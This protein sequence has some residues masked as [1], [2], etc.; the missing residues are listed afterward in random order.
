MQVS[1]M[2]S[3]GRHPHYLDPA[4]LPDAWRTRAERTGYQQTGRYNEIVEFCQRLAS[5]SP[6]AHYTTF[7]TSGEGRP[8]PLLI[9]SKDRAFTPQAAASDGKLVVLVLNCIHPG[10]CEGKDASLELARDILITGTRAGLLEHVDLLIMPI[11]GTDG[12]ERFGPHNRINQNGPVE[13][14]WRVTAA[15]LN[16]NRDFMKADAV[17]MQA[18]LRC[19]VAWRPDFLFD[20]HT[21]DGGDYQY[22]LFYSTNLDGDAD[23]YI[24][25]WTE[26]VLLPAILPKLE[27]HQRDAKDPTQGFVQFRPFEPRLSTGYAAICNRPTILVETHS[28]KPY[29]QRVRGTYDIMLHTLEELNARPDALR[30]AIR[31]ADERAAA[32][33]GGG[34]DGRVALRQTSTDDSSTPLLLRAIEQ[35][36]RQSDITGGEVIEYT[37]RPWDVETRLY[38][39]LRTELAVDPPAAYLV[40]PQWADAIAR[41]E[42]HG[43]EFFRLTGPARLEVETYRLEAVKFDERPYEGRQRVSCEPIVERGQ[44]DFPAGTVVVPMHQPRAKLAVHLL[45][46]AAVDS[47]LAWGFFNTIFQ[48]KEYAEAYIMEPMARQML[49]A[50]PA[51][52]AEFEDKLRSDEQFAKSPAARLEFFY[53]RSPHWD[54]ALSVYPVARLTDEAAL[55]ALRAGNAVTQASGQ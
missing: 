48:Q 50:D 29:G 35:H 17:E 5:A 43:V 10:E 12:H 38:D 11:F 39:G 49:A 13:A 53:R 47:L 33:R 36:V 45:E 32:T 14:G 8:L 9:L 6:C 52:K 2:S 24:Q 22:D 30:A 27:A 42:L 28:L 21:T 19:W 7:G 37:G 18:W 44:R 54:T 34:E 41:L 20:N 15:N 4:R 46:P 1:C 40:P 16:L 26:R 23:P 51:L 55:D 3:A 25:S 31:A